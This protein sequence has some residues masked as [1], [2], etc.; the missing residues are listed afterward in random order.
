[1][2]NGL[3][4]LFRLLTAGIFLLLNTTVT[5]ADG[6]TGGG[7][8]VVWQCMRGSKVETYL[9]DVAALEMAHSPPRIFETLGSKGIDYVRKS[10]NEEYSGLGDAVKDRIKALNFQGTTKKLDLLN[11][12]RLP[13]E[14]TINGFRCTKAQLAVQTLGIGVV[15]YNSDIYAALSPADQI[16]FKAHEGLVSLQKKQFGS[17]AP[18]RA[19]V[20]ATVS[21]NLLAS[22]SHP[23]FHVGEK[24]I[25]KTVDGNGSHFF[26][27]TVTNIVR[28]LE[29]TFESDRYSYKVRDEGSLSGSPCLVEQ[30]SLF[31]TTGAI[32]R[33]KIGSVIGFNPDREDSV[34]KYKIIGLIADRNVI[35]AEGTW[36]DDYGQKKTVRSDAALNEAWFFKGCAQGLCVGESVIAGNGDCGK[37]VGVNP[38]ATRAGNPGSHFVVAVHESASNV[39]PQTRYE[40]YDRSEMQKF[41][42]GARCQN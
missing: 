24:V 35:A 30:D 34:V 23:V 1:M 3:S 5:L 27:G 38:D 33:F 40:R 10:L 8:G 39:E 21:S 26:N 22:T 9:A 36:T 37:I 18:I 29:A 20:L 31:A 7:G 13:S 19:E 6:G 42:S 17:T 15:T 14:T 2:T 28:N 11:D 16:L 41:F 4:L 32:G 25:Y 12:D